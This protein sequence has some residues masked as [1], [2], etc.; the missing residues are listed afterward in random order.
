MKV[1]V[2][3]DH[4]DNRR[5]I[6]IILRHKGHEVVEA[7]TGEEGVEAAMAERPDLILMDIVLPGIDGVETARRIRNSAAVSIPI[8]ALTSMVMKSDRERIL[9]AGCEAVV[10]KPFD[11]ATIMETI[12]S[13]MRKT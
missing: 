7:E 5:L 3:E 6:N 1:L 10:E 2:V 8:I 9:A 13:I 11:P 12:D 4:P